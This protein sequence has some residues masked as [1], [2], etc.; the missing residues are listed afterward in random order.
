MR[1]GSLWLSTLVMTPVADKTNGETTILFSTY[2]QRRR[3]R[4]REKERD[5]PVSYGGRHTRVTDTSLTSRRGHQFSQ[6]SF[7]I[8][9]CFHAIPYHHYFLSTF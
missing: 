6:V 5:W 9:Q 2:R 8:T 3:E 4:E 1:L 7:L